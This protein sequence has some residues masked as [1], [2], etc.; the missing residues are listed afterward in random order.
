MN[1][2]I[3][4][5]APLVPSPV[6]L[7][8]PDPRNTLQHVLAAEPPSSDTARRQDELATSNVGTPSEGLGSWA[9]EENRDMTEDE[10]S[11][12]NDILLRNAGASNHIGTRRHANGSVGS[13][14]SG[15]KIRHLKK[16]DGIPL[17]R[18]DIQYD[19]LRTVFDDTTR[20]FTCVSDGTPG[21][22]FAD[23]YIDAMA[24]SAK[25]SKILKDKLLSDRVAATNMAMVCLL[26]NVG[27]MNTTLNFFPEMR[28]QLRTYHSIPSLQ[29]QQDPNAY[30]QLQ[31]APRLKSILK[32]A[33]E[34]D[35]QREEP[36]TVEKIKAH[37]VP[38]TNPVNLIFVISQYAPKI[39]ELHFFPPRDFFDL[40]MRSTLSSRSR[41][42]GFLWL[43]WWYL[44]SNFTR[45]AAETNPFGRGV[46]GEGT[47][48][49]PLKI[50]PFEHLTE[51]QSNAE[52]VDTEEEIAYG[53]MKREERK[54]IIESDVAAAAP[55]AKRP[56]KSGTSTLAPSDG[57]MSPMRDGQSPHPP[58]LE[59]SKPSAR[60]RALRYSN[61]DTYLSDTDRTRS[62]S[63]SQGFHTTFDSRPPPQPSTRTNAF[64]NDDTP[65]GLQRSGR[66]RWIRDKP[67][68]A[69]ST[70]VILKTKM[71]QQPDS[72][73]PAPPGS[74]HP[75]LHPDG[76]AQRR[77]R[78]LTA[79]QLAVEKNRR[80]RV[81][82]ILDRQLRAAHER[83]HSKRQKDGA[84]F[85]AW[86]RAAAMGDCE[87]SEEEGGSGLGG[88]LQTHREPDDFGAEATLYAAAVRRAARRLER[89]E[90]GGLS[91]KSVI[92]KRRI[93]IERSF[94]DE[95]EDEGEGQLR[96]S[97]VGFEDEAEEERGLDPLD[98]E[99]LGEPGESE[100]E[101]D[102]MEEER[103]NE[104]ERWK[105][106]R[107]WTPPRLGDPNY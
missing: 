8:E 106:T 7:D 42:K 92:P 22:T 98:L 60:S 96:G 79:H 14:Y 48:G 18:K 65:S 17:W 39:S 107:R 85:R 25:T 11:A 45:H 75:I 21:H 63:P 20:V 84:F 58:S 97:S 74:N 40:V 89:W 47:K 15:N 69:N 51:E 102:R 87:D 24:K 67:D 73:S 52:N 101:D 28:A 86:M 77:P 83:H 90:D 66:G 3:R 104:G 37:P 61:N 78:P 9:H 59:P 105:A 43:M 93:K 64:V 35:D 33:C 1:Q 29:A 103:L 54:R 30:K 32:G 13:V 4:E 80:A 68:R 5:Q 41:A 49:M 53:D 27:R 2:E 44:E 56:K 23:I 55:T 34:G 31:D 26:V 100:D 71:E 36:N 50:P 6:R 38:R 72:S 99:L 81:N 62:A 12:H 10:S 88:L 16:E 19:F 94:G 91:A 76:V 95:G 82:Y 70:R 46:E 57:G